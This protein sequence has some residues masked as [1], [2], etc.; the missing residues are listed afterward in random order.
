MMSKFTGYIF[1]VDVSSSVKYDQITEMFQAI[2]RA[3][4]QIEKNATD[5][6]Q[7]KSI[8][9]TYSESAK[10]FKYMNEE[11]SSN[12]FSR[13]NH[14][15]MFTLGLKTAI[16]QLKVLRDYSQ[17]LF[18]E[19]VYKLI[20]LSDTYPTD[21][22]NAQVQANNLKLLEDK[23]ILEIYPMTNG[24]GKIKELLTTCSS[25][26]VQVINKNLDQL[27]SSLVDLPS[28]P[29]V[30]QTPT[31]TPM[32][33]KEEPEEP[34]TLDP[35]SNV[36]VKELRSMFQFLT[37]CKSFKEIKDDIIRVHPLNKWKNE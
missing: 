7:Q 8:I 23:K 4:N 15:S 29:P 30:Q 2:K 18:N 17:P 22:T 12:S 14:K 28:S 10:I 24:I 32:V 34:S 33:N 27:I 11:I 6:H 5:E 26:S 36:D 9:I 20:I 25:N 13:G 37:E 35:T 31:I 3:C 19:R 16:E 21:A 1:C